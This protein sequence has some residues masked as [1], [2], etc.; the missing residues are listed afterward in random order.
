MKPLLLVASLLA[1]ATAMPSHAFDFGNGVTVTGEF[2]QEFVRSDNGTNRAFGFATADIAFQQPV[3]SFGGFVGFDAYR[4]DGDGEAAVYGA[5]SF[6]GSF[7]KIQVGV[8]RAV[9]DDY[10]ETPV[11]GNFRLLD[12]E[13]G[14]LQSSFLTTLYMSFGINPPLGL[15]YD[16][17]IGNARIGVSYHKVDDGSLLD[18]AINYQVNNVVLRAG[19][20][21]ARGAADSGTTVSIGVN[22]SFGTVETGLL[23]TDASYINEYRATKLFATYRPTERLEVTGTMLSVKNSSGTNSLF[24]LAADYT[25][26]HGAFIQ[27]GVASGSD[28]DGIYNISLGLK[29]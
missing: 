20:E 16:G 12:L 22:A 3:G 4:F 10:L 5:L 14:T 29:F 23:L 9:I 1:L 7:G 11:L 21:H 17:S 19:L 27:A 13:L 2:E 6:S 8:P 26:A 15:R 18:A 24:G 28:A 25:F